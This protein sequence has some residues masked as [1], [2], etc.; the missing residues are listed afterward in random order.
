M[1]FMKDQALKNEV[2]KELQREQTNYTRVLMLVNNHLTELNSKDIVEL[3]HFVCNLLNVTWEN[4]YKPTRKREVVYARYCMFWYLVRRG[5]STPRAGRRYNR[6]HTTVLNAIKQI[7]AFK[8]YKDPYFYPIF[9]EFSD[10]IINFEE[11]NKEKYESE[12]N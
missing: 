9:K 4:L 5:W 7:D 1:K 6:D 8:A 11:Q 10:R 12:N 2:L 3:E